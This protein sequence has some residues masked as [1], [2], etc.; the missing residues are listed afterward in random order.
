MRCRHS[1]GANVA[2]EAYF[3]APDRIAALI[4]VAPA[5]IAPPFQQKVVKE[6]QFGAD[7][8]SQRDAS[9]SNVHVNPVIMFCRILSKLYRYIAQAISRL[10]KRVVGMLNSL[11]KK[12]LSAFLR[13]AIAVMLVMLIIY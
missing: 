9:N 4:L 6:N 2:V 10:V 8:Q 1:A 3:E 13:S 12:A 7:K 11:Y 5:I